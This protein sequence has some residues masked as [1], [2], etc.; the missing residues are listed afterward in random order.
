MSLNLASGWRTADGVLGGLPLFHVNALLVTGIAPTYVGARVVWP[1]P[2]GY[3][4]QDLYARFW[5]IVNHY[6]ITVMSAVPTVYG[7]L[8]RVPVDADIS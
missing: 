1:G 6:G 2:L 3:R 8:A 4:S 5:K 7:A